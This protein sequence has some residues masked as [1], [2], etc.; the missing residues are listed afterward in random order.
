METVLK[1]PI[2]VTRTENH[3]YIFNAFMRVFEPDFDILKEIF[4]TDLEAI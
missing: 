3:E 4:K 2:L 1:F